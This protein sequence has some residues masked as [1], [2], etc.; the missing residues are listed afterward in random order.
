MFLTKKLKE[1][2]LTLQQKHNGKV[3]VGEALFQSYGCF[4][5][6]FLGEHSLIRLSLLDLITCVGL[7]YGFHL[8]NLRGFSW[9][10]AL[11]DSRWRTFGSPLR[12]K[13]T[14]KSDVRICLNI[15]LT[16][17]TQIQ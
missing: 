1:K 4:F 8:F 7:R 17:Q 5:A 13:L 9:K 16:K 14:L 3:G 2:N 12:L 10:L 11:S 6:E 15:F